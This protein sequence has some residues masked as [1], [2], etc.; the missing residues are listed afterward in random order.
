MIS[1]IKEKMPVIGLIGSIVIL[2]SSIFWKDSSWQGYF[3][4]FLFLLYLI[5]FLLTRKIQ[6]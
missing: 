3:V 2:V 5:L 1:K 6:K 4:F